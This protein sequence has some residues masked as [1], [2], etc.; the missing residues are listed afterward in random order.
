M[1]RENISYLFY[2]ININF[3]ELQVEN[4]NFIKN[5]VYTE[6][7]PDIPFIRST[8]LRFN[9]EIFNGDLPTPIFTLTKART[10]SGKMCYRIKRVGII[11]KAFDFEMR[12]STVFDFSQEEWEDVVIHEMIHLHIAHKGITDTSSHGDAFRR[13]MAEINRHHHRH[14]SISGDASDCE[15]KNVDNRIRAHYIC[16]AKFSDGRIG[17]APVAKSR[18]FSLWEGFH[19]FEN[20]VSVKWIGSID[21]WFNRFPRVQK[22]KL[23]LTDRETLLPHLKGGVEL[24]RTADRIVPVNRRS[25]PDE[26]LP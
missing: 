3:I 1:L 11:R 23:Y 14:I 6:M 13:I 26:L 5:S 24:Q 2:K 9:Y 19:N 8:F 16:I 17:V 10:F 4:S 15:M 22:L 25:Y 7:I 21:P 18:I 12:I 20:V